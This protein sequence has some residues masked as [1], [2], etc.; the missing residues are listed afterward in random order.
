MRIAQVSPQHQS[1]SARSYSGTERAVHY[2]T[3]ALVALGHDVTMVSGGNSVTSARLAD[4]D[5]VHFHIDDFHFPLRRHRSLP[6]VTT[7]HG[8]LDVP[9]VVAVYQALDDTP[10]VSVSDAQRAQLPWAHWCG[11]VPY[12]LP[13]GL[14]R[15]G[16]GAG[17]YLAFLG[18][19]SPET[20]VDRAIDI[21]HRSGRR[22]RIAATVAA[23]DRPY[24]EREIRPLFDDPLVQFIGEIG[25]ADREA[26]LGAAQAVL[27]PTD[28]REPFG[29]V[30]I[31]AMA[32]GTPSIACD[33]GSVPEII[34]DGVTGFIV[35]TIDDAVE[36]V[37]N[38]DSIFRE[39][40]RREFN[41]RFTAGRMAADYVE[42]YQQIA[43][44]S[45]E[46]NPSARTA[47]H[48]S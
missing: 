28:C 5:V 4:F 26:F 6:A 18:R 15:P 25:D 35:H 16:A 43:R 38:I 10:V 42:I 32:C 45:R 46:S 22:L 13:S 31:E 27:F 7:L 17:R 36:A 33:A 1:I 40:C 24:F 23:G 21:A 29:L 8:R 47:S 14:L 34:T 2:L 11:T 44:Q 37:H 3:E 41:R 9:D 48:A 19:I 12:G 30:L 20:R 39:V